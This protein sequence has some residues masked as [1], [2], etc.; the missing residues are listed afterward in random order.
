MRQALNLL[1][2]GWPVPGLDWAP[3]SH[4]VQEG[5]NTFS[6]GIWKDVY[7]VKVDPGAAAIEHFV[8]HT[9]YKGVY[10]TSALASGNHADFEVHMTV[11]L[12]APD[13]SKGSVVFRNGWGSP[14]CSVPDVLVLKSGATMVNCSTRV[15]A[16][17]ISLWWPNNVGEGKQPLYDVSVD[18]TPS[19][20]SESSSTISTSR[21]IGFRTFAIVTGKD[22]SPGYVNASVGKEGTENNGM[23]FRVNG[24]AVFARG[25]N[26]IPMEELEGRMTGIALHSLVQSAAS[27]GFNILRNWGGGIFLP[28]IWYDTCDELGIMIYHDMMFAQRGHSP[29]VTK[30]EEMEFRHQARRLSHH[31]SIVIWDGC[32][33]CK[34]DMKGPTSIYATFLLTTIAEED[35]MRSVWPACPA[36]GWKSEWTA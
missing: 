18:Y 1:G 4:T 7:I 9:F 23:F 16:S 31:P 10:P 29:Q 22:E 30:T 17:Q 8:P 12:W 33:E 35:R 6:K 2:A 3:Y 13:E 26:M 19:E 15:T 14:P 25:A 11:H 24:A 28:D 5:A 21:R 27:A 32:N 20:E 34:V 36:A